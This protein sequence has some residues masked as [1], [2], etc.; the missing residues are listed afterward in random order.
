M[1]EEKMDY[2]IDKE[3]I[4]YIEENIFPI[5]GKNE[6]GH[7]IEH[8]KKVI[9][10]SLELSNGYDVDLN[11]IYVIASYHDLGHHIDK[12]KHEIISGTMLEKDKNLK[13]WF[14]EKEIKLMKEAVE[15]HRASL[16][17]EP[18]SI[19]GK[20]ISSADRTFPDFKDHVLRSYYYGLKHFPTYTYDEQIERI[21][22]HLIEK[23]GENGYA[24]VYIIDK[25]YDEALK[26]FHNTLKNKKEFIIKAKELIEG[27][28]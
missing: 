5:Y 12:D 6:K 8:I 22:N 23:Y 27:E 9:E 14:S 1:G 13:K 3:I 19:Y 10:R 15:D 4:S 26:E 28:K 18:R 11:K 17:H 20:I 7:G 21:Y 16:G 2:K 25:K 24:K